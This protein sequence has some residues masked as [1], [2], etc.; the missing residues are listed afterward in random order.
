MQIHKTAII[1]AN[2]KIGDNCEI[3]AYSI[4]EEGVSIGNNTK[5]APFV[6][7]KGNTKI[8]ENNDIFTGCV[9]GNPPQDNG[10]DDNRNVGVIIGNNNII[11]E[12]VTIHTASQDGAVTTIGNN[13]F[14]M[15]G[16]HIAHDCIIEDFVTIVNSTMIAGYVKIGNNAF[17]SGN[18]GIHQHCCIGS[19][20]MIGANEKISQ[21]VVPY[22]LVNDFPAKITGINI[23]GLKRAGFDSEK[24]KIIKK[25]YKILFRKKNIPS[26]AIKELESLYPDNDI[27]KDIVEFVNNS[28][29][30]GRGLLR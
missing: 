13:C 6:H 25:A 12:H 14:I 15:V 3:G 18:V 9:I 24:R 27:I 2:A 29:I 26:L 20:A 17:I 5:I 1:D 7:I 8:G 30:K 22:M 11:R 19:Y 28:L 16:S 10:F 23:V 21:D 4:I